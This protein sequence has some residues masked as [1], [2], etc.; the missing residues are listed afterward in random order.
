MFNGITASTKK[1]K[2]TKLSAQLFLLF[3]L[4]VFHLASCTKRQQKLLF[5]EVSPQTSRIDFENTIVETAEK[6]VMV[7]EYY[8]NGAGVAAADFNNDGLCDLYFTGNDVENKLYLNKGNLSFQDV[9]AKAGVKG[10]SGWK[11][12]VTAVDINGD[13]WM[14]IYVS[15]SG[16]VKK[17]NLSEELYINQGC[18]K[19]GVP[20]FVQKA[21]DYGLDSK[22]TFTTQAAFFDFDGDGDLDMFQ[23]N[24]AQRYYSAFFNTE[25]VRN[26]RHPQFGS[27]LYRNDGGHFTDISEEAGIHGGG[28]NFGLGVSISDVNNDGLPDIYVTTD[29]EEQDF[30]YLNAGHGKFKDVTK[31]SFGHLSKFAMGCDIAD[32]NNDLLQDVLVV[33]MLPEK[34]ERQKMLKGPDE[35]DKYSLMVKSG[36]QSQYMRN[37]FQLNQGINKE[38]IPLFSE[39]GQLAGIY[40]TDWS[41]SPLFADFDN[42]GYKDIFITNGFL[43][44]FTN[45]DFLKYSYQ[46][47]AEKARSNGSILPVYDLIKKMPAVKLS[48]Y[49]FKN[50]GNLGF[51]NE[52]A[53]WGLDKPMVS[54][55]SVYVDLDN[56]GDLELVTNNINEKASIWQ[57]HANELYG[58]N[59]IKVRL[60]GIDKNSKAI[61]A[62]VFVYSK[63][64]KQVQELS[65]A[66]GFQ[67][68]VDYTLNF[69][70]GTDS[71][72]IS[73]TVVWPNGSVSSKNNT[74]INK[75]VYFDELVSADSF[76]GNYARN[77][78]NFPLFVNWTKTSGINYLHQENDFVDFKTALLIPYELSKQGPCLSKADVN[79][80]GLDDFF[81]G[82]AAGF[83]G[84]LFIQNSNQSFSSAIQQPFSTD[85]N[86]EDVASA[87]FDA[88]GDGDMDLYVV[89]GSSEFQSGS[90]ALQDRL[91]INDGKG[92][93]TKAAAGA[94]PAEYS[95]G[96]C[97]AAADYDKDGDL[98]LFVGSGVNGGQFPFPAF[99][100]ILRNDTDSAT[101]KIKFTVATKDVNPQL[102]NLGIITDAKWTDLNNDTWPDLVVAGE[103]MKIHIFI[104]HNGKLQEASNTGLE[105][106]A[107]LWAKVVIADIDGDGD[108]DMIAGNAGNNNQWKPTPQN[109]II[110][111]AAD[112][113]GNGTI[114]PIICMQIN[115]KAY[116]IASL[117]EFAEKI[118][119]VRKKFIYYKDFAK[120]SVDEIF[121]KEQ[122]ARATIFTLQTMQTSLIENTGN[123]HFVIKPLPVEA[124]FS[125]VSGILFNDYDHDGKKDILIAGNC[126]ENRVQYGNSDASFGLLLTGNGV[127]GF[128]TVTPASS[129]FYANGNV[130]DMVEL[131]TKGANLIVI[132]KNNDS[133]QLVKV[134]R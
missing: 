55:G 87:F 60:K 24:H 105:Q 25:K 116:P 92:R 54:N 95:N 115:G 118:P 10:R 80:D 129:G 35:F 125:K 93:F 131:K 94:I 96:S 47:A 132:G 66:R 30:L 108:L 77:T 43:R 71:S 89:S 104:N 28:L 34:L 122:L 128:S 100:G 23:C 27:R 126:F 106:T 33:D 49:G 121:T 50:N 19:D 45:L 68:S 7:Y 73:I 70:L 79:N 5:T 48:N 4:L 18:G 9:T 123:L 133:L 32:Y 38:G 107:G 1:V 82:G 2:M 76:A 74:G 41:W 91:Y 67:S 134:V 85:K 64:K 14:D 75:V 63:N 113:D 130:R 69:G 57:N 16:P 51:T 72:N 88:D 127:G 40:N 97:V 39:I 111:Y 65:P 112:F 44:D 119:S 99:G 98:D 20:V 31:K 124:Q 22:L 29:F 17:E 42:D 120:A 84:K 81:V 13:G 78:T 58:N 15:Y 8:Y 46:D 83:E 12:G 103:W 3:L 62:K 36:F 11:T 59:F 21:A 52:T 26:Q 86:C 37:T 56:D 110:M 6:N 101:R 61:G 114:D 53:A 90:P 102:K 109:P 117:D